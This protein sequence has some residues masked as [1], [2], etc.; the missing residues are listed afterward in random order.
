MNQFYVDLRKA[1]D[2]FKAAHSSTAN[3]NSG[4]T[5]SSANGPPSDFKFE[6]GSVETRYEED[7]AHLGNLIRHLTERWHSAMHAFKSR[8][9]KLKKC[10][11]AFDEQRKS[12]SSSRQDTSGS[13]SQDEPPPPPPQPQHV[14][15]KRNFQAPKT[16][17]EAL[18]LNCL[19]FILF[20]NRREAIRGRA[21]RRRRRQANNNMQQ[22]SPPSPLPSIHHWPRYLHV[23]CLSLLCL[24]MQIRFE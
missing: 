15:Y 4:S 6:H 5:R 24:A 3:N 10:L 23:S 16:P 19:P 2:A 17:F 18:Y 20:L 1:I 14:S 7:L 13:L 12:A 21:R 22:P 9:A 11:L 8:K